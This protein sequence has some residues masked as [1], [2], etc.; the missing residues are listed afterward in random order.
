MTGSARLGVSILALSAAMTVG[1]QA[2]TLPDRI[3]VGGLFVST[4]PA[5]ASF[6]SP[7]ISQRMAIRDINAQGGIAGKRVDLIEADTQFPQTAQA[8]SEARRLATQEKVHLILG[9]WTTQ[10]SLAVAPIM[11]ESDLLFLTTAASTAFN[12]KT[13]PT[14]FSTY[15]NIGGQTKAMIDFAKN[16]LKAQSVAVITDSGGQGKDA[17]LNFKKYAAEAGIKIAAE[18]EHEPAASDMTAQL[19]SLRRSGATVLLQVASSGQDAGNI[20]KG[21]SEIGW[22]V[23]VVSQVAAVTLGP[24][25]KVAGPNVFK[26]GRNFGVN[27]K[28]FMFCPSDPV[29]Q[30]PFGKWVGSLKDFAPK[31]FPNLSLYSISFSYDGA[32][33]AKAAIEATKTTS[34]KVLAKWLED[35]SS[36][37]TGVSGPGDKLTDGVRHLFGPSAIGFTNHPDEPRADYLTARFGC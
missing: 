33:F 30:S 8:V 29:G 26:S 3:K 23:P 13:A 16:T 34:G 18:Q 21:M 4:G 6:Y 14:G 22:D 36:K 12:A 19:L 32:M 28:A 35:N 20:F 7:T 17:A 31:D 2:Q 10:E 11:A 5:V 15:L 27:Y 1:A 25:L 37:L 24:V 9:P